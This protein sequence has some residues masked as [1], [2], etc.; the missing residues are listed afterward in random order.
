MTCHGWMRHLIA[1]V[2]NMGIFYL[3]ED[4]ST[5]RKLSCGLLTFI[6][7][8]FFF[9][10]IPLWFPFTMASFTHLQ[11]SLANGIQGKVM[12]PEFKKKSRFWLASFAVLD[13]MRSNI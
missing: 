9:T 5:V 3:G 1:V 6:Y 12:P 4:K 11:S 2:L 10:C 13:M 8:Y 7:H